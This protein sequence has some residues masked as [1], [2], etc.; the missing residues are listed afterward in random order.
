M[1]N[2]Q[3]PAPMPVVW[4]VAG[5]D[6]GAGVQVDLR[7]FEAFGGVYGCSVPAAPT[8]QPS[9]GDTSPEPLGAAMLQAQLDALAQQRP[10]AAIKTGM[11]G[12][13]ENLRMLVRCIDA[14]R[15]ADPALALVVDPVLRAAD[16]ATLAD[17][18]LLQ[19]MRE[20]LLPCA[21]LVAPNRAQAAALL[22]RRPLVGKAAVEAAAR[23]L[24]ALGCEAVVITGGDADDDDAA[25]TRFSEDYLLS[26]QASGWLV[27][28]RLAARDDHAGCVFAAS[29]AAAL[30]RGFVV[31]DAVILARMA[32]TEALRHGVA[33]GAGPVVPQ[34]GFAAEPA[35]LPQL[36]LPGPRPQPTIAFAPLSDRWLGLYAV[37][38]SAAWVRRVLAA[39]VRCV[40]LRIKDAGHPAL[41]DEVRQAVA[42]ARAVQAQL[43][44]NDHWQLAL[45]EGAYGVH[46]GQDDLL[47]GADLA[48][49]AAAGIRL[50]I[51]SHAYW[52]VCRAAALRPSYLACGP[53][54]ATDSKPMPWIPQGNANLAYWCALLRLPVVAIAGMDEPRAQ[55]AV[56][57]GAAGV[58]V[59]TA[60]T[61]AE[62]PERSIAAFMRAIEAARS[63]S[64][65]Q[66]PRMARP[67]L[68]R[69][70]GRPGV[71]AIPAAAQA[72]AAGSRGFG[73]A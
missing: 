60:I 36:L 27:V 15:R 54:H 21:T 64:R 7:A 63:Q 59:I 26:P 46:L 34:P 49:L 66:T 10:P 56:R 61:R 29:A 23:E 22:G 73:P 33:A 16:G 35:N 53:I 68:A 5:C 4:A 37:V 47:Q 3:P 67:T 38:D 19:A 9:T 55:E 62:S 51:S 42:A 39:G 28:P 12:G 72:P 32:A 50:G 17:A 57:S 2:E 41:R 45:E 31:A 18:E 1:N 58:A 30:A 70:P 69:L 52:E 44:I 43:F 40:Q 6:C 65:L 8:A 11:L 13:V 25:E 71:E 48:R 20:E 14:L 24:L